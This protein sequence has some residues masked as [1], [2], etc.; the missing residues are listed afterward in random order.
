LIQKKSKL[1]A[2]PIRDLRKKKE[3]DQYGDLKERVFKI[4]TGNDFGAFDK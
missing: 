4:I 3:E 1:K 2:W